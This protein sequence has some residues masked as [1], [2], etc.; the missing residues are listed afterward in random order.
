MLVTAIPYNTYD[1]QTGGDPDRA[2]LDDLLPMAGY[3]LD[4]MFDFKGETIGFQFFTGNFF[5]SDLLRQE[6]QF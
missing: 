4:T 6:I 5:H 1:Q 2:P 3:V